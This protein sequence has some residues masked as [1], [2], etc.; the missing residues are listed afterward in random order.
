MVHS[1]GKAGEETGMGPSVE[2]KG[3]RAGA[4]S[5]RERSL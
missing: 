1:L 4:K 5:C 2:V 3:L